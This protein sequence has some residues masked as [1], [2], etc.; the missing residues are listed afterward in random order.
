MPLCIPHC[1]GQ[2]VQVFA[3]GT[4]LDSLFLLFCRSQK[5]LWVRGRWCSAFHA[6]PDFSN[7]SKLPSI[8]TPRV[9][10]EYESHINRL[11]RILQRISLIWV[12]RQELRTMP[13]SSTYRELKDCAYHTFVMR[14]QSLR[15]NTMNLDESVTDACHS[16][17]SLPSKPLRN[18]GQ[19][20]HLQSGKELCA[21]HSPMTSFKGDCFAFESCKLSEEE[22]FCTKAYKE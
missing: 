10:F 4:Y 22:S 6:V 3:N 15:L 7:E 11:A 14:C 16:Q 21:L 2:W 1:A 5:T 8:M 12:E 20:M 18:N 9:P 13:D 17:L 19:G